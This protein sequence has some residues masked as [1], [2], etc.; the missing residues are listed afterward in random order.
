MQT[1]LFLIRHGE[2]EN[3]HNTLYGRTPIPLSA[4]GHAQLYTL[5]K[6]IKAEGITPDI[7]LCSPMK[8]TMESTEELKKSFPSAPVEYKEDLQET[9]CGVLVGKPM[10]Y[11][12][13]L[14]DFYSNKEYK[15][16]G[17]ESAEVIVDRMRRVVLDIMEKYQGK[18]IFLVSH[19]DPLAFL[20][21]RLLNPH[22]SIT[23]EVTGA[24]TLGRENY[25]KR[26]EAW[27]MT[28]DEEGTV[29]N[30][31]LIPREEF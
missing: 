30:Y 3:P 22:Q 9:G 13:S 27:E 23:P 4:V 1:K 31:K 26:G 8:R 17:I 6:K 20:F 2:V 11:V 29:I 10:S 28:L 16:L 14:G 19:G 7:I 5:G 12:R 15:D 25:L 18:T 21:W 24:V